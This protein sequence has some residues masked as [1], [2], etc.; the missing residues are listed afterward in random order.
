[1]HFYLDLKGNLPKIKLWEFFYGEEEALSLWFGKFPFSQWMM[2]LCPIL[3]FTSV[4]MVSRHSAQR[5]PLHL[6]TPCLEDR[7]PTAR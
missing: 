4:Y 3:W 1:M 6:L 5:T 7:V 2:P